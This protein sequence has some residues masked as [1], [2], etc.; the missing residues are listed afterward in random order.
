MPAAATVDAAA[1]R[2]PLDDLLLYRM[3]R[4]LSVAGSM[5]IRLC[6]GRFGI[7]R[8][9][10]RLIAVLASRGELSSSQLAE[11][12][13]LD[14]ARTSKAVGSLV[15]KQLISRVAKAGDRRQVQ[16]GLTEAGQAL[17]DALFPLVTK[18]N[19]DL[20]KALDADDA[21]RFDASLN[22]LQAKAERMVEEAVLPKADRGRR[23]ASSS[24]S[25]SRSP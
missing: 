14:R 23:G 8:R 25:S 22:L 21:A 13:Q 17:Y 10:W 20:M 15:A 5:V 6:E 24:P 7:T 19:G 18:I 4:L 12:A 11:H 1:P 2:R 16:L 9:E 3:S